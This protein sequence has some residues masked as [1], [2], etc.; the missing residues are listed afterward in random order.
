MTVSTGISAGYISG[1][2][3]PPHCWAN[4]YTGDK[5]QTI[6][7]DRAALALYQPQY[8]YHW[9]NKH[10]Y[11]LQTE[12]V[13]VPVV[14]EATYTEAQCKW[15]GENVIAPQAAWL[16]ARSLPI[17]LNDVRTHADTSG[18]A[19]VNWSGRMSEQ[20]S[21]DF[22]GVMAHIDE[23]GN[24]HWDCSAEHVDTMVHYAKLALGDEGK[25]VSYAYA[26]ER[27]D[28]LG[29]N[30]AD[31]TVWHKWYDGQTWRPGP[32][33]H[34]GGWEQ[35]GA[36]LDPKTMRAVSMPAAAWF[37]DAYHVYW[38]QPDGN[39]RVMVWTSAGWGTDWIAGPVKAVALTTKSTIVQTA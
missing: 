12:I 32:D 25:T 37:G 11:T 8:G 21:A 35:L 4:P 29:W 28:L 17:D 34:A 36:Q 9:C 1:H 39:V 38:A 30:E 20:E 14:S 27:L 7:L 24:D 5:W 33:G 10:D 6:E 31:G 15:I 22:N 18:S 3:V 23:W 2:T 13:G 26:A 16:R 19:S